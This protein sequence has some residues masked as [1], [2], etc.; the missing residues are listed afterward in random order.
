MEPRSCRS[1]SQP[2]GQPPREPARA[3][4]HWYLQHFCR[5]DH[6]S[7]SVIFLSCLRFN[8][9]RVC[10]GIYSTLADGGSNR[11]F[12]CAPR[13]Y[14]SF[15]RATNLE[16]KAPGRDDHGTTTFEQ[17]GNKNFWGPPLRWTRFFNWTERACRANWQNMSS[18]A[19]KTLI[20]KKQHC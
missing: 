3:R 5:F 10:I 15:N 12:G 17:M 9:D 14:L 1:A 19:G 20:F 11:N 16:K 8:R 18:H 13:P 4:F 6:F 7:P 2:A